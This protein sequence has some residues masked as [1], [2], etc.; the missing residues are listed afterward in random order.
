M[1]PSPA[2]DRVA[3][4]A[5]W[6]G[7]ALLALPVLLVRYPPMADLPLH[8]ASVALLRHW[9]DPV[10]CPHAIYFLNLGQ[11]NQ[12]YSLVSFVLAFLV[13]IAWASKITVAAALLA[14]P[15][16]AAAFAD[17]VRAPRWTALLVGPVGLGW[18][19]F[20]GLI[21]NIIGLAVLLAV[22]PA[23]DRFASRPTWRGVV[24]VCGIMLLL[25]FAHQ[26]M[27]LVACAALVFCSVGAPIRNRE[28]LVRAAPVGFAG[29]LVLVANRMAW[30]IS[31]PRHTHMSPFEWTSPWY[32]LVTIPGVLF[33]GYEPYIRN[34]VFALA[35]APLALFVAGRLAPRGERAPTRAG[36][37]GEKLHPWRFELLG[38]ALFV[39][40][41]AAPSTV[42]S[43]TLVYHRFLPPA[44]AVLAVTGAAG[45]AATARFLPRALCALLPVASLLIA[46]PTFVD[47]DEVY[48]DLDVLMPRIEKGST[49]MA[50]NLGPYPASRLWGPMVAMGR[51][52]AEKGGRS[53]FDYSQSPTSPVSMRPKKQWAEAISRIEKHPYD[54]TPSW[55]FRRYRYLLANT[56]TPTVGVAMALAMRDEA[57]L[58]G[59]Q[60]GWFLF[61]SRL[62]LVRIDSGDAWPPSPHPPTLE[63]ELRKESRE[64]ELIEQAGQVAER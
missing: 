35:I 64:L 2:P 52:V 17:H 24:R 10:F 58:V 16:A 50:I 54:L 6:V 46:W 61:E 14:L 53:L 42:Q 31:G 47:A 3:Q 38:L 55:D 29:L 37:L 15:V 34:L 63:Y 27:L 8:E 39:G 33:A 44:W 60:G 41:M 25:H 59:Q 56:A 1:P 20:W 18:L 51:V 7:G 28:T 9:N 13:P 21:Q 12:L 30:R 45:T 36:T 32:K 11:A 5:P 43:T 22:L 49:I 4:L 19:F 62:Q 40:Y 57:V 26:A 48:S 23:I